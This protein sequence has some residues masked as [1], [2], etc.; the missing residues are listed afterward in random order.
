MD[1]SIPIVDPSGPAPRGGHEPDRSPK[2]CDRS[3]TNTGG[4]I[5]VCVD[6]RALNEITVKNRYPIP[7]IAETLGR[8]TKA[9]I[10]TLF[11]PSI[12]YES[13]KGTNG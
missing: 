10:Y 8:L 5:R 7:L 3:A 12:E 11:T 6:Y 4:G 1:V 13:R 2:P 9:K